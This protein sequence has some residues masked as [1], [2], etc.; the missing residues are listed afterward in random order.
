[1]AAASVTVHNFPSDGSLVARG[2]A[3][4]VSDNDTIDTGLI[5]IDGM[6][7]TASED[8]CVASLTSQSAGVATVSLQTAGASSSGVTV[9]WVAWTDP[10]K[11]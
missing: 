7:M 10:I 4:S 2:L 1:M 8:D 9:Y 11:G 5:R 6:L 3:S